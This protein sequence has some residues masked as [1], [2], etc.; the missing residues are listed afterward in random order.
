MSR[1]LPAFLLLPALLASAADDLIR[2]APPQAKK[3][4]VISAPLAEMKATAELRLPAQVVVPPAQIEVIAAPLAG[5]VAAVRVAYGETVRKGQ[6]LARLQGAQ[7]LELQRDF[8]NARAQAELAAENRR[9]DESLFADGIIAGSRLSTTRAAERQAG[10]QLAERRQTLRLAGVTEPD[11]RTAGLSGSA[12]IVAPF[13]GVVLEA[14]AQAGQRVDSMTPLFKLG[15]LSPLWL[16]IQAAPG[17]AAGVAPGDAVSVAGCAQAGRVTLVAPAMQAASQSLLIRAELAGVRGCVM[18]FQ[19]VQASIV[20]ASQT[21]AGTWRLPPAALTRHQGQT[22]V[23]LEAAEGFKPVAV[24]IVAES[25]EAA[26]VAGE[27]SANAKL[28]IRGTATLKAIW[29]GLGAGD[30]K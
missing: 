21:A 19:Y 2:L 5:M 17:Q 22:W 15:R 14:S 4:G 23:F 7:L 13:D 1:L 8:A 30:G 28:A 9:R 12:D 10:L 25:P 11:A 6:V 27:L 29:L 26:L 18:P 16:E 24:K 20:S 3:A